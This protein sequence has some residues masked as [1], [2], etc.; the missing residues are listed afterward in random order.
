MKLSIS[1][2]ANRNYLAK[3]VR[4]GGLKPHGNADR[5]M[6]TRI[7][8]CNIITAKGGLQPGDLVVYFPLECC[9]SKVF[10]SANNLYRDSQLNTDPSNA[11][12]FFEESGRVKALKLR[13]EKSEG[14]IVPVSTLHKSLGLEGPYDQ[15]EDVEFDTVNH[16]TFVK[17]Y[18]IKEPVVNRKQ[19]KG[20]KKE[21]LESKLIEGQFRFH[22]DTSKFGKELHKFNPEDKLTITLKLHGTSF[23]SSNL[24]VKKKLKWWEKAL[25][26]LK[27][28][29][30]DTEYGNI[31]SSRKVIKNEYL[32]LNQNSFYKQ[33]VWGSVNDLLKN[34]LLKGETVYGEIV[35][36]TLA[37]EQI[38][39]GFDYGCHPS[40]GRFFDVYVYKITHTNVDGKVLELNY[41]QMAERVSE[42]GVKVVPL[43]YSGTA[44]SLVNHKLDMDMRNWREDLFNHIKDTWVYDQDSTMCINKVPEEGVVVRKEGLYPEAFKL[45]SFRFL[46]FESKSLDKGEVNMEDD[47]V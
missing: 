31:Y 11:G 32:T 46:E 29:I 5:L 40:S 23:V 39:K 10:L 28:P 30:I 1:E 24:L 35:G 17:K 9:I 18:V 36:Y 22:T 25:K 38:Q 7:D 14:F 45:K 44:R 4:L 6:T 2:K 37:G 43:L 3:I 12:G 47:Q 34:K 13:G 27:I 8:G 42:I 41:D 19:G 33:D 20:A 26:W 16:V 21:L 15:Y